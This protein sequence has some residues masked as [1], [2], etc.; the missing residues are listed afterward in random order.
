M[1][2]SNLD[3]LVREHPEYRQEIRKVGSWLDSH[4]EST[5]NPKVVGKDLRE[6]DSTQLAFVLMLLVQAGFLKLTYKVTTPSGVMA[7]GEFDDPTH[8][9]EKLTDRWNRPFDTTDAD[10]VPVFR[11]AS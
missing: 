9:P 7:D 4:P 10:V 2:Q 1:S 6:I 11:R 5:I 8:I 3:T